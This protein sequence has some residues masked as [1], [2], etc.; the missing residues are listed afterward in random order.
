MIEIAF[1]ICWTGLFGL[2]AVIL[3]KRVQAHIKVYLFLV[4]HLIFLSGLFYLYP[5]LLTATEGP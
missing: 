4:L 1:L 5:I 2:T 3:W